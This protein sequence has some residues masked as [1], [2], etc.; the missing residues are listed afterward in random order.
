MRL[1]ACIIG[2]L[3]VIAVALCACNGP[4]ETA[5]PD[6]TAPLPA[7]PAKTPQLIAAPAPS[8]TPMAT[9][10]KNP[11]PVTIE[12]ALLFD[13]RM[14]PING[15]YS[16]ESGVHLL[17]TGKI[18]N[19]T[20]RLLHRAKVYA[21]AVAAFPERTEIERHSGG[22]GFSPQVASL[23]PWRPEA[24]RD[25]TCITRALD[26]IYLEITPEKVMGAITLATQDPLTYRFRGEIKKFSVPWAPVLGIAER[27]AATITVDGDGHCGPRQTC[28][29]AK[30]SQVT[31]LYQRGAAFKAQDADGS[32]FWVGYDQLAEGDPQP[33]SPEQQAKNW[34]GFPV[35]VNLPGDLEVDVAKVAEYDQHEAVA[36]KGKLV[37]I[38]LRLTNRGAKPIRTPLPRSFALDMSGGTYVA[39]VATKAGA[40]G[41]F[42]Q[43]YLR[44]GD[45]VRGSLFFPQTGNEWDFPFDL[46]LH[47]PG[48]A[49]VRWPLFTALLEAQG[50]NR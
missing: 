44:P 18:G 32:L 24:E 31:V 33:A 25:F 27:H 9:D 5:A 7:G 48:K 22:L 30:G 29:L 41:V 45:V 16:N 38:E 49:P 11:Y 42:K 40:K 2:P 37:V 10:E 14:G 8:Q 23:D 13:P 34:R 15:G 6:K 39:P 43:A 28:R 26:P 47:L 3:V 36:A 21:T 12:K 46:E 35:R 20:G 17:V 1:R 19:E 50:E 4:E